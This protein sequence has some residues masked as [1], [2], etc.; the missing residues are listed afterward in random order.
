M[1]IFNEHSQPTIID[2]IY[3]PIISEYAWVLDLAARDF[4]LS[5]ITMVEETICPAIQLLVNGF[6]FMLPA[7]W[8]ILVFDRDTV[9][10]DVIELSEV[11]GRQFTAFTYGPAKSHPSPMIVTVTDYK[12]EHRHVGPSLNKHQMLCHPVGPEEW[13]CVGHSDVYNK[14]LKDITVGDLLS[15]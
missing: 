14:Y 11:A 2:N 15:F 8:N 9:Q 3:G 4:M 6:E 13:V 10:L 12:V 5:P 1:L 7:N